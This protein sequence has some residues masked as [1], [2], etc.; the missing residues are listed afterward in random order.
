MELTADEPRVRRQLD[1]L[2]QRAV[3]REA[4]QVKTMLD[5]LVA[6]LVVDLIAVTVAL[7]H[8]RYAIDRRRLSPLPELA[9]IGAESHGAAHVGDVLLIFHQRDDGVAALRR[10]L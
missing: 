6:V 8:L 4:T 1:H 2:D 5:E 9:G 3:G 7:A 10:E